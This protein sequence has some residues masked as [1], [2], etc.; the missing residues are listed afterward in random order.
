MADI[1][2]TC[3]ERLRNDY[4]ADFERRRLICCKRKIYNF[5]LKDYYMDITVGK[6]FVDE[7]EEEDTELHEVFFDKNNTHQTILLSG[8]PGLGKSALCKK[9]AYD[10]SRDEASTAYIKHFDL[11]VVINLR[12][13]GTRNVK[14][15]ILDRLFR[16]SRDE[17]ERV[18]Q[19][20]KLNLLIILD[21]F[22]EESNKESVLKFITEESFHVSHRVTIFVT[23]RQ[24]VC[25]CLKEY[26]QRHFQIYGF[27]V[28]QRAEYINL[29]FRD[30]E[31]E[32][33]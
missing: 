28:I 15:S 12:D 31:D 32:S 25:E 22:D 19:E 26:V 16:E 29:M 1:L 33:N 20:Q 14:D 13:L 6:T 11:V 2:S 18:L 23:C 10:W 24:W 30:V 17:G 4:K 21:E 3:K 9:I 7:N 27:N 5:P 8:H